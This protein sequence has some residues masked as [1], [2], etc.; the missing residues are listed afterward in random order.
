MEMVME[1]RA[2]PSR[3]TAFK[4]LAIDILCGW[5]FLAVF[6]ITN[7]IFLATAAGLATGVLQV[8]WMLARRQRIDP[9]QWMAMALVVG[10]GSATMLTR[11]P[12]FVVFKP[13]IFEACLGAMMLRPGW[14]ARYTPPQ[15]RDLLPG[16]LML[17]WGYLWAFAWFALAGSNLAVEQAYGLRAWAIWTNFSPIVLAAGLIGAG[18]LVFP[19]VVRRAAR[20]QGITFSRSARA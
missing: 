13:S 19:P 9:M 4:Q 8:V 2:P 5:L 15:V 7:N 1:T 12:R 16:G 18:M 10:L 17:F 14:M 3:L 20:A 11:D 6:L